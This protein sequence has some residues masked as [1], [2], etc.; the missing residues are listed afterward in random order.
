MYDFLNI[1][2]FIN[3]KFCIRVDDRSIDH[4]N[5]YDISHDLTKPGEFD[6][7][8]TAPEAALCTTGRYICE[9]VM[10]S[11][12]ASFLGSTFFS[13]HAQANLS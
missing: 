4:P 9:C 11:I 12:V 6:G 13:T 10:F 5:S 8:S 3:L 7:R 2:K 1:R